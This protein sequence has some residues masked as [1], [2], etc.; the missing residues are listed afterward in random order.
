[1]IFIARYI[2]DVTKSLDDKILRKFN[3]KLNYLKESLERINKRKV[4]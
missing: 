2:K 1:M 4:N 3:D